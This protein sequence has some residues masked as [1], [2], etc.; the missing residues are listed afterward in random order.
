M[1][2]YEKKQSKQELKKEIKKIAKIAKNDQ[3]SAPQKEKVAEKMDQLMTKLKDVKKKEEKK[4]IPA[5]SSDSYKRR[6]KTIHA[7]LNVFYGKSDSD[8]DSR[9][10]QMKEAIKETK[11]QVE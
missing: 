11:R 6:K 7:D 10:E 2:K 4:V 9:M 8:N 1:G 5:D 3:L